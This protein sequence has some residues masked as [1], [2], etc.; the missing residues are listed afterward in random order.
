[1][2]AL[3]DEYASF[4]EFFACEA[5]R[6]FGLLVLVRGDRHEAEDL[7][8]DAFVAHGSDGIASEPWTTRRA[9]CIGPR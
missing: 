9:T 6:L 8:Q 3:E 4:E 5:D 7:A 2:G 1:M